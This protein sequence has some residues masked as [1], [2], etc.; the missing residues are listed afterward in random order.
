MHIASKEE[1]VE[2]S[3][4]QIAALEQ[5]V[6]LQFGCQLLCC[7]YAP[8]V[9][10]LRVMHSRYGGGA[11]IYPIDL[12]A[13]GHIEHAVREFV[14]LHRGLVVAD[15]EDKVSL[16]RLVLPVVEAALR[17]LWLFDD[18]VAD[19]HSDRIEEVGGIDLTEVFEI[20][21]LPQIGNCDG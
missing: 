4:L 10:H 9:G 1:S 19:G 8:C 3:D 17:K 20:Q 21:T 6:T 11:R 12:E 18:V 14:G 15:E 7:R 2:A 13:L 5:I 16:A